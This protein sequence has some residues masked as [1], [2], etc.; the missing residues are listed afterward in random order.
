MITKLKANPLTN[1]YPHKFQVHIRVCEYV[2]KYA[3]ITTDGAWL[4]EEVRVAGRVSTIRRQG[5]KLVFYVIEQEKESLQLMCSQ[6]SHKGARDFEEVH[7]TIRRGDIIGVIG[8]PGRTKSSELSVC[9][10]DIQLLSPC[11]HMLPDP[12]TGFKDRQN[13]YRKRYLDLIMNK[14]TRDTFIA[15]AKVLGYVRKYLNDLNFVQVETPMMNMI[16][17]GATARPFMTHHNDLDM[18]LFMRIA[19]ELY[20]KQLIVGG[21]ERVFEIGKNFR[22]ESID[23]T[24]NP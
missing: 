4:E 12:H 24:H 23:Q 6:N 13:R 1:P 11:L 9:V 20:L 21:F 10:Q 15:R 18:K 5:K 3:P 16:P 19:P 22:N 17:G 8:Q 14:R 2:A 7:S